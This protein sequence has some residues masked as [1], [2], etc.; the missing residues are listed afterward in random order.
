MKQLTWALGFLLIGLIGC[1]GLNPIESSGQAGNLI[2]GEDEP[3]PNLVVPNG[4]QAT[5]VVKGLIA[6]TQMIPGPD[7]WLWVAQLAGGE[8]EGVGQILAVSPATGEKRVLLRGVYKPTGIAI[9]DDTLWISSGA[10]ILRAHIIDATHVGLTEVAV[11]DLPNNGR[12]NGTLTNTPTGGLLYATSSPNLEEDQMHSGWLWELN[13]ADIAH[14]R[15]LATGIALAYAHTFDV[16][17]RLWVTNVTN[18]IIDNKVPPDSLDLV[19]WGESTALQCFYYPELAA[20]E[21]LPDMCVHTREPAAFF[22]PHATPTGV[23]ASPWETDT[24]LVALWVAG[25]IVRVPVHMA[26]DNAQGKWE[27]FVS[28]FGNP[29][30][31][32]VLDDGSLLVSDHGTGVI[33]R[34]THGRE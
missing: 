13:P 8:N 19:L 23:V 7:G 25:E 26:G 29:Q 32:L 9:I 6:P 27:S 31:L 33:Y 16:Q 18:D 20:P 1:Q 24:L 10:D 30:H 28:G 5:I 17:D 2:F 3:A 22:P 34:I 12:S 11:D 15:P 21:S 4:Y 14:P